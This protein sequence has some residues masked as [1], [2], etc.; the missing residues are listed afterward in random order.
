MALPSASRID[1]ADILRNVRAGESV[2]G[3]ALI[4]MPVTGRRE[5]YQKEGVDEEAR[6]WC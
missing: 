5:S 1:F 3:D 4:P 6:L 2:N